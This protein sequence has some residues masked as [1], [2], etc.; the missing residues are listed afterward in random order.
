MATERNV[1]EAVQNGGLIRQRGKH[2]DFDAVLAVV[3][4]IEHRGFFAAPV[5]R[6]Q[7]SQSGQRLVDLVKVE[8]LSDAG[9]ERL[10][11][12]ADRDA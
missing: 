1:L 4:R 9:R 10:N 5:Y 3:D 2:D 11:V 8:H 12:L 6:H 7:E